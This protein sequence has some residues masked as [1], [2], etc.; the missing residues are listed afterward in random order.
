MMTM[1][2]W[3]PLVESIILSVVAASSS[4]SIIYHY[5][6]NDHQF[7]HHHHYPPHHDHLLEMGIV[8]SESW[9]GDT[10]TWKCSPYLATSDYDFVHACKEKYN[11]ITQRIESS[12]LW[13]STKQYQTSEITLHYSTEKNPSHLY[14]ISRTI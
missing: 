12:R 1:M 14:S 5:H 10:R 7:Y 2:F 3:L 11:N 8:L 13:L 4:L 9:T 6:H